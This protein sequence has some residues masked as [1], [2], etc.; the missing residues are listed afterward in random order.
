[1]KILVI[2]CSLLL[3][4]LL[5][6]HTADSTSLHAQR[7]KRSSED[8]GKP[9]KEEKEGYDVSII[10]MIVIG[11]ILAIILL[12]AGIYFCAFCCV[13]SKSVNYRKSIINLPHVTDFQ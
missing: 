10:S 7:Y 4:L 5:L 8:G 6:I 9:K 2:S 12:M 11:V 1:M 13:R 3:H